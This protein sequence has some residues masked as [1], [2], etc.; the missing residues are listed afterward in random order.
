MFW[1]RLI[2]LASHTSFFTG[3]DG[4]LL[5][6]TIFA[7]KMLEVEVTFRMLNYQI[8]FLLK[9]DKK[10]PQFF[11]FLNTARIIQ[12]ENLIKIFVVLKLWSGRMVSTC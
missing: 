9:T 8:I 12:E 11:A 4:L 2:V 10:I 1:P 6:G 3:V 7:N 5:R